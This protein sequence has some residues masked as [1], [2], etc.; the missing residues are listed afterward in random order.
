MSE[1][2]RCWSE[3]Y[4]TDIMML[5][6]VLLK[7]HWKRKTKVSQGSNYTVTLREALFF[8]THYDFP[9]HMHAYTH[10]WHGCFPFNNFNIQKH[11]NI[12]Q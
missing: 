3:Q 12:H 1:N 11:L 5:L 4:S 2:V 8:W 9:S 6:V 10:I 7:E